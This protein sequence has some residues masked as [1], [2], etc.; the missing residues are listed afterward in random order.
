MKMVSVTVHWAILGLS[1][2]TF[3]TAEVAFVYLLMRLLG[4]V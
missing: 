1:F 3:V 4:A 2:L